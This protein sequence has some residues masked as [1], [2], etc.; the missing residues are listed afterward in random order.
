MARNEIEEKNIVC[1]V[2]IIGGGAAGMW[3]AKRLKE[4]TPEADVLIVDKGPKD[5][6][7]LMRFAGGDFDVVMPG[8]N[9][10][11]WIKELTYYWDNLCDQTKMKNIFEKSYELFQE[12]EKMGCEFKKDEN[13]NYRG[14]PQ[15][16]LQHIKLYP[17]AVKGT[18]GENMVKNLVRILTAQNVRRMGRITI[19]DLIKQEGRIVGAV[20]FDATDATFYT[21]QAK[22]VVLA[23]GQGGWKASY[24]ANT[25]TA[26]W[27][28]MGLR[29][30][31]K[32]RNFEFV[33]VGN[34]PRLYAWEGISVMLPLGARF[35]NNKGED[36]MPQY[37]PVMGSKND[38][39]YNVIAMALEAKKGNGP[40]KFDVE[41]VK[42][43]NRDLI[44]PQTGWQLLN[45]QKLVDAGI[46]LFESNTEWVPQLKTSS[47]GFVTEE[48]GSTNIEGLY[49]TGTI[50]ATYPTVYL[51]GSNLLQAAA[52]GYMTGEGLSEYL[53][54]DVSI[55]SL[56]NDLV[57]AL[58]EE[59]YQPYQKDGLTPK[60]VMREIQSLIFPCDICLLK[61]EANLKKA[62]KRME[63][64]Q[65]ILI[66]QM[67]ARDAHYLT[68]LVEV[69]GIAL[70]TE[71]FLK[72]SLLREESRAGHYRED[73]PRR[74]DT[75]WTCWL[76][77][78]MNENGE[79]IT[80]KIRVP[81]EDY[82]HHLNKFMSDNYPYYGDPV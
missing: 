12:Y 11:D 10:D 66:P 40:I 43:E 2:L 73:F 45:H 67:T 42:P 13:G 76:D 49:A 35:T 81:L 72:N 1:D 25:R 60:E 78:Y 17:A 28:T 50:Q 26:D 22:A 41:M 36:F 29:A 62:L 79:I 3:T 8:E 64:V 69:K 24:H 31:A 52:T 18:G 47:A 75:N 59:I 6:G 68:K 58:K 5:W 38:S 54:K 14:V 15:R 70:Q 27:I 48:D 57:A 39:H 77:V 51:G 55:V 63:E 56:D 74:D 61:S 46:N 19:Y 32:M 65:T 37:S 16:G 9:V 80:E 20:G 23:M 21:F 34:H 44:R 4:M 71:L 7:G 82:P 30:G 53:K 33:K